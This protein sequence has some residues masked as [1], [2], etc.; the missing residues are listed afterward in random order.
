LGDVHAKQFGKPDYDK[1]ISKDYVMFYNMN[2]SQ[3]EPPAWARASLYNRF[4]DAKVTDP[5]DAAVT[6]IPFVKSTS[7][8]GDVDANSWNNLVVFSLVHAACVSARWGD[9]C[10][11]FYA[12]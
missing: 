11:M 12:K 6:N 2:R 3:T 8:K 1:E 4:V 7:K 9:V 10:L 5:V